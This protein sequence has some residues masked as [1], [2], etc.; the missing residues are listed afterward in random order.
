MDI[1]PRRIDIA[2]LEVKGNKLP[3]PGSIFSRTA[4]EKVGLLDAT[5]RFAFDQDLFHRMK[6][7]GE[8]LV[9]SE[10]VAVFMWHKGSL[11]GSNQRASRKES[12]KARLKH[13]QIWQK[14]LALL[15]FAITEGLLLFL[16]PRLD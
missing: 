14:P 3:Q 9:V 7:Q 15:H 13:A 16:K 4:L 2:L 5:L 12:F 10:E 1:T 11:S 6:T 8:I